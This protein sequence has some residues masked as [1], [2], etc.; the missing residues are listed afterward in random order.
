MSKEKKCEM[1]YGITGVDVI[2]TIKCPE[3]DEKNLRIYE[4]K[5]FID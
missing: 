1:F 2:N 3:D 4:Q 5:L